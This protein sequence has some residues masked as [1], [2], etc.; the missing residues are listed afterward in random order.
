MPFDEKLLEEISTLDLLAMTCLRK[1]F[2]FKKI[3]RSPATQK[4]FVFLIRLELEGKSGKYSRD[5]IFDLLYKGSGKP[6]KVAEQMSKL[7]T[8]LDHYYEKE[9]ANDAIRFFTPSR[10]YWVEWRPNTTLKNSQLRSKDS[11]VTPDTNT[12]FNPPK[13]ALNL[14]P[15]GQ[16]IFPWSQNELDHLLRDAQAGTEVKILNTAFIDWSVIRPRV[17]ELL[18]KGVHVK[19]VM[20]NP[21]NPALVAA[22]FM[23][24]VDHVPAQAEALIREQLVDFERLSMKQGL[25]GT[26]EVRLSDVM[27]FAFFVQNAEVILLG[28]L[29][30]LSAYHEGPLIKV[31]ARSP[32]GVK[33]E[34]DWLGYWAYR[35]GDELEKLEGDAAIE[36]VWLDS[37]DLSNDTG[38]RAQF[39]EIVRK[40]AVRGVK[41]TIIFP[42]QQ[43]AETSLQELRELFPTDRGTGKQPGLALIPVEKVDFLQLSADENPTPH[44]VIFHSKREN[45]PSTEVYV[46]MPADGLWEKLD[47]D[48]AKTTLDKFMKIIKQRSRK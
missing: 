15:D 44:I 17:A 34:K 4:F 40:N 21:D 39:S 20:M 30:P 9:G 29:S 5:E 23:R 28:L 11:A 41:Y 10:N 36:Q 2:S 35:T 38:K 42:K 26:L 32:L 8:Y 7:R 22:R 37:P 31:V 33:L 45:M 48:P 14:S 47:N 6:G 1:F 24:R 27:P 13:S 25:R 16:I 19:I 18:G 46:E 3:E 12:S 43:I